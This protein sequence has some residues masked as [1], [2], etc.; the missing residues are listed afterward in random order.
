MNFLAHY[1]LIRPA[2]PSPLM[3]LGNALPDLLPLAAPRAR[4]RI[5]TLASARDGFLKQGILT[6]L[7]A[8]AAF[9]KSPSFM[10]AQSKIKALLASIDFVGIRIRP[11]FL[12]HVMAELCLDAVLLRADPSLANV[13]YAAFA[14]ADVQETTRWAETALETPLPSLPRVLHRFNR[15]HYLENYVS[16]SGVAEGLTRLCARAHQDTFRGGNFALLTV[17]VSQAV[18]AIEA[19][20]PQMLAE[21]RA[22][23][24]WLMRGYSD[25]LQ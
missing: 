24:Q 15:S 11:F 1:A 10:Q 9:H 20:A 5:T 18:S 3:V 14:A 21:T 12:A 19:L 17:L 16:D 6:H 7:A 13:F 4:F 23:V 8:D 25:G 22:M 2:D